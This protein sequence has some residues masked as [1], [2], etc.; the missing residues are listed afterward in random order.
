[1]RKMSRHAS[2]VT[3]TPRAAMARAAAACHAPNR[4][5]LSVFAIVTS[6]SSV[7]AQRDREIQYATRTARRRPARQRS[8]LSDAGDH[9]LVHRGTVSPENAARAHDRAH[10]DRSGFDHAALEH[11]RVVHVGPGVYAGAIFDDR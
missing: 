9:E 2:N 8:T 7:P 6:A 1:M 10:D 3:A 11:D 5:V 4:S